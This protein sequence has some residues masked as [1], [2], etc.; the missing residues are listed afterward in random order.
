MSVDED[1]E[2]SRPLGTAPGV[3]WQEEEI[4]A[5]RLDLCRVMEFLYEDQNAASDAL[6]HFHSSFLSDD[7]ISIELRDNYS[8]EGMLNFI[9][10]FTIRENV[11][12]LRWL[13]RLRITSVGL[14]FELPDG[15]W[16]DMHIESVSNTYNWKKSLVDRVKEAADLDE[17]AERMETE[18]PVFFMACSHFG[19]SN[20]ADWRGVGLVYREDGLRLWFPEE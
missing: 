12:G 19:L 2:R 1:E 13:T 18:K 20:D 4:V 3:F 9:D 8:F 15:Q 14:E 10:R 7:Q 5:A 11:L 17:V 16:S 6:H